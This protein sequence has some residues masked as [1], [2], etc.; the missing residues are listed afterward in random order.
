MKKMSFFFYRILK[1][2]YRY[3]V[4]VLGCF[5]LL[6]IFSLYYSS[7]V[8]TIYDIQETITPDFS[9]FNSLEKLRTDFHR[10]HNLTLLLSRS[11]NLEFS[12]AEHCYIKNYFESFGPKQESIRKIESLYSIRTIEITKY[13]YHYPYL[14]NLDCDKTPPTFNL[15]WRDQLKASPWNRILTGTK[16]NDVVLDIFFQNDTTP[17]EI[18][19]ILDQIQMDFPT[20]RFH[21]DYSG[22]GAFQVYVAEGYAQSKWINILIGLILLVT[23]KVSFGSFKSG[24]VLIISLIY[25]TLVAT[26]ILGFLNYPIDFLTQ[27]I[28]TI[29][30]IA[31]LEDFIFVAFLRQR[32]GRHWKTTYRKLIIPCFFTS[33]TTFIGFIALTSSHLE[34][35]KRFGLVTAIACLVEWAVIFILLPAI[36]QLLP[37]ARLT[38]RTS[39]TNRFS[40]VL[41]TLG[42]WTPNKTITLILSV[43]FL[44]WL[45]ASKNLET[46]DSPSKIF[47]LNHPFMKSLKN[48]KDD[49]GWETQVSVLFS[50]YYDIENF[51]EIIEKLKKASFVVAVENP[52]EVLKFYT[53]KMPEELHRLLKSELRDSFYFKK[54]ISSQSTGQVIL[55]ISDSEIKSIRALQ[56]EVNKICD[57]HCELA[58]GLVSYTEFGERVPRTLYES[59]IS[60]LI[61]IAFVLWILSILTK[62]RGITAILF[63]SFWGPCFIVT[64][65]WLTQVNVNYTT[66]IFASICL[67]LAGDNAI[68]YMFSSRRR[69]LKEGIDQMTQPTLIMSILL[70]AIPLTMLLSYFVNMIDLGILFFFGMMAN[71]FG[72]LYLLKAYLRFFNNFKK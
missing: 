4:W 35:I 72:D 54:F 16:T 38:S 3:P 52:N 5:S 39:S 31:T 23:F 10:K 32:N 15:Q 8:R 65:L 50:N 1:T 64:V 29:L 41:G 69:Q 57:G 71:L 46:N 62:T 45:P 14:L 18:V 43:F 47:H 26:G 13:G 30:T 12:A 25:T 44:L 67:G 66:C 61:L 2:A 37:I 53:D 28:F 6:L 40:K 48:I 11:D 49:R 22:T 58:N 20:D 63:S 68:Q 59:M 36:E 51:P 55:Y 24:L 19:K 27:S 7:R 60:G 21:L 34:I 42:G 33:L 9:T 17:A 56:A 70:M